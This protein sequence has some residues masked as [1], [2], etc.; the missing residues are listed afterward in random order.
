MILDSRLEFSVAQALTAT[1]VSTNVVDLS[2]D[3][4]IGPGRSMWVVVQVDEALDDAEGN[5]TYSV[6]LQTSNTEGS[7]YADIATV[8][9]PRG[10][11]AG[12]R[13]V[14]GMPYANDRYLRLNYTLGGTTPAGTV[15]A[16]LTDQEP[17]SWQAY[18]DAL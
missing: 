18:P 15:S 9:L 5:E 3:R 4:N 13:F 17:A 7:G 16:W 12:T 1:A 6:A 10:S 14:I 11:A 2:S 8:S